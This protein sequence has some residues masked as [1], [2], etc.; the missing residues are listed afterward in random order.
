MTDL[1][2]RNIRQR[3]IIPTE[4]L[5]A[6]HATII[7][8]GAV[9]RQVALQAAAMGISR[10][11]LVDYDTV[12]VVNLAAQGFAEEDLGLSKV[13]AVGATC[14]K[15]NSQILIEE[16]ERAW[17]PNLTPGNVIFLCVDNIE[18]REAIFNQLVSD[19]ICNQCRQVTWLTTG[20]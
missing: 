1:S 20:Q 12:D 15:I 10:L 7:G 3:G 16:E 13:K 2:R 14:R 11:T 4:K 9:G 8:V 6:T 5:T 17:A 18:T 19:C